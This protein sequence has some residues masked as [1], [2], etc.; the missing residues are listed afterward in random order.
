MMDHVT[1][2]ATVRNVRK[3]W[4]WSIFIEILVAVF[5]IHRENVSLFSLNFEAIDMVSDTIESSD[6]AF[7]TSIING[8]GL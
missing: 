8:P 3:Y 1:I 6:N 4:S 5:L 2:R 7:K